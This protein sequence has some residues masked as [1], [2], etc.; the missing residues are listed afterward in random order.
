MSSKVGE[1]TT[2]YYFRFSLFFRLLH[3]LLMTTFV[4]LAATGMPLRFN[5]A[6]WANDVAHAM[7]GFGAI[8]FFHRTFAVL[9]TV[10][11]ALHIGHVLIAALAERRP[12]MFWGPTS[13]I[14]QPRDLVDMFLHFRWFFGL[15]PRP[16]FDRFTYWEKF[17]YWAVFWGMAIIGTSGYMLWFSGFFARFLP[18]RVFNVALLLH[19][20]EALLA[21][22]FI[23]AI[24]FFNN[25]L[26]PG[27]F[28]LDLVIF[29]G[30]VTEEELREERPDELERLE[31]EGGLEAIRADAPP[32]WLRNLGRIV[33]FTV[34]VI[35][36][37]LF[38]LTVLA[39]LKPQ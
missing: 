20:E 24:H 8:L 12:G 35:G 39:S 4:G 1:P 14:P 13:M 36:F 16:R 9:M 26:R 10:C 2:R 19:S 22:W 3:V 34:I 33:G 18:G 31:R 11:F 30:R 38:G 37:L 27:K 17:D 28:P 5:Q 15:G 6:R 25:H 21:V 7:G 23:F 29:T 32:L